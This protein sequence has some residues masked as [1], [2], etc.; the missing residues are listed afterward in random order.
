M[1]AEREIEERP[2]ARVELLESVGGDASRGSEPSCSVD[3]GGWLGCEIL[4]DEGFSKNSVE[5]D[6]ADPEAI[7]RLHLFKPRCTL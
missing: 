7:S 5:R 3:A 6:G 2:P 4:L 1:N